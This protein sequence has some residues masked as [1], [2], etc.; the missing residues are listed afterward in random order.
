[1][2][3]RPKERLCNLTKRQEVCLTVDTLEEGFE[4]K[5]LIQFRFVL[6]I[7]PNLEDG[8]DVHLSIYVASGVSGNFSFCNPWW[9]YILLMSPS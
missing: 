3:D 6:H 4:Q 5:N 9:L 1:M 8:S 2:Y 7:L